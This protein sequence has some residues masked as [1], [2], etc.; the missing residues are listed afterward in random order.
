VR[1]GRSPTPSPSESEKLRGYT[2]YMTSRCHGSGH[3][4]GHPVAQ[5]GQELEVG[6]L[7]ARLPPTKQAGDGAQGQQGV[8]RLEAPQSRVLGLPVD[9]RDDDGDQREE[10]RGAR[11]RPE[12]LAPVPGGPAGGGDGEGAA[13][14]AEGRRKRSS[15]EPGKQ[16]GVPSRSTR[17]T[18]SVISEAPAA[19]HR[20]A[21]VDLPMPERAA[22]VMTCRRGRDCAGVEDQAALQ[23]QHERRQGP[24]HEHRDPG[25]VAALHK[26]DHGGAHV[27]GDHEVAHAGVAQH[28]VA[29]GAA[30]EAGPHLGTQLVVGQISPPGRSPVATMG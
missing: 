21:M 6:G 24:G 15:P 2:W 1:P 28:V 22:K 25:R 3:L 14:S 10:V 27:G 19:Q 13:I 26:V 23:H 8:D 18:S 11:G 29:P 30:H 4:H 9:R 17:S 20:A 16:R 12:G 5:V 7:A